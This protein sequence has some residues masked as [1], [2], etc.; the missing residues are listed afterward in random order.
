[1]GRKVGE[2]FGMEMFK[3]LGFDDGCITINI[4]KLI[5][6]LKNKIK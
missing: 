5:G 3:K 1:M 2:G 6:L 4:V